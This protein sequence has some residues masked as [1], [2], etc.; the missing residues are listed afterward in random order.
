MP[1][2]GLYLASASVAPGPGVHGLGGYYAARSALRHDFG[3]REM[4]SLAPRPD[5]LLAPA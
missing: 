4:P 3:F 5:Q 1:G 2:D